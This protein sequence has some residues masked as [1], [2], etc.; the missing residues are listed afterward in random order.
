MVLGEKRERK[1]PLQPPLGPSAYLMDGRDIIASRRNRG[2][3]E[4]QGERIYTREGEIKR[5]RGAC[6]EVKPERV[7]ECGAD[8]GRGNTREARRA[9]SESQA[10][11]R[12]KGRFGS[13][14]SEKIEQ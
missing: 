5:V 1:R 7:V 3:G 11:H 9:R 12:H 13:M 8:S 14:K 4:P 10:T 2:L 6:E